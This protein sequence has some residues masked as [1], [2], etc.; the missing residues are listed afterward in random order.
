MLIKAVFPETQVSPAYVGQQS[1]DRQTDG[2]TD[3]QKDGHDGDYVGDTKGHLINNSCITFFYRK[4]VRTKPRRSFSRG[5]KGKKEELGF[6]LVQGLE[7]YK[8]LLGQIK[9]SCLCFI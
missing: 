3:R 4:Q 6:L 5:Y 9:Q 2:W 1:K 7:N 8:Q